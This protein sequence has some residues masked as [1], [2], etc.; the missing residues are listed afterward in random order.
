M[1]EEY[2]MVIL[3]SKINNVQSYKNGSIFIPYNNKDRKSPGIV[4][5]AP[6]HHIDTQPV[7]LRAS[8]PAL[9]ALSP[10]PPVPIQAS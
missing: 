9:F 1:Y 5:F 2:A 4:Q 10:L 3:A 7:T 8:I 6:S